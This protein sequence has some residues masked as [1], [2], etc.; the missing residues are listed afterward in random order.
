M[1]AVSTRVNAQNAHN[2][3]RSRMAPETIDAAVATKSIW[4]NQSDI[5]ECPRPTT[6]SIRPV[7]PSNSAASASVGPWRNW[8]APM[9]PST[10][11]YMRL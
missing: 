1:N 2:L 4:K 5:E 10:S 7:R 8:N 6:S 3:T 11:T 9:M